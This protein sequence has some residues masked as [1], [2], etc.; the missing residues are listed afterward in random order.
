MKKDDLEHIARRIVDDL[1]LV[2]KIGIAR[3]N[4]GGVATLYQ[5]LRSRIM[6]A[7]GNDPEDVHDVAAEI[8]QQLRE[9]HAT[10]IVR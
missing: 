10:R 3:M 9:T 8:W 6:V 2:E 1:P 4:G 7:V 5:K